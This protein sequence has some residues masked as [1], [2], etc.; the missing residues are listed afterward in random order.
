MAYFSLFG[1]NILFYIENVGR[2]PGPLTIVIFFIMRRGE[3]NCVPTLPYPNLTIK[4]NTIH[5]GQEILA[6]FSLSGPNILFYIENV[7]RDLVP[8]AIIIFLLFLT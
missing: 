2:D 1:P 3:E 4:L 5:P 8:L 7:G 6:H